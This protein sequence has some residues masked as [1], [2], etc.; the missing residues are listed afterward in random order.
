MQQD[1][2]EEIKGRGREVLGKGAEVEGE[3][4]GIGAGEGRGNSAL[5][6]ER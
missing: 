1:G 6:V 2:S 3:E 5:V 4:Y